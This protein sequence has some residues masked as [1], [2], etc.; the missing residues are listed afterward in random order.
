MELLALRRRA[1]QRRKRRRRTHLLKGVKVCLLPSYYIHPPTCTCSVYQELG[2]GQ[3]L[4]TMEK[5]L[6][7][8]S[9]HCARQNQDVIRPAPDLILFQRAMEHV[10]RLCRVMVRS[11]HSNGRRDSTHICTYCQIIQGCHALL[12][13]VKGSGRKSLT[14]FVAYIMGAQ[15]SEDIMKT[16]TDN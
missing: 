1:G 16:N 9:V 11:Q 3:V 10:V 2:D 12:L 14:R 7:R 5:H 4:E 8:Y 6:H 15:V 13:G